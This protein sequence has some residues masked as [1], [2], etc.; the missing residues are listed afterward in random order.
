ML[1][2]MRGMSVNNAMMEDAVL[3]MQMFGGNDGVGVGGLFMVM[4]CRSFVNREDDETVQNI[5]W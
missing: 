2:R 1:N 3:S 5:F 4:C